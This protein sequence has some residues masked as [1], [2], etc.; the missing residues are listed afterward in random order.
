MTGERLHL[1]FVEA[2]PE[3]VPIVRRMPAGC[4]RAEYELAWAA[5]EWKE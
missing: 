2:K 1:L 5:S 3:L 4:E